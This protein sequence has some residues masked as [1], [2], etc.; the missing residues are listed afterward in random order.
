VDS[1]GDFPRASA[2]DAGRTPQEIRYV[3]HLGQPGGQAEYELCGFTPQ[4]PDMLRD[5]L[6]GPII[7]IAPNEVAISDPAS[8]KEIYSINSGFTKVTVTDD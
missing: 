3:P 5:E 2:P 7:R 4:T 6:V 1:D 8:I